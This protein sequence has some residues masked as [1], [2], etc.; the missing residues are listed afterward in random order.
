MLVLVWLP[1][2]MAQQLHILIKVGLIRERKGGEARE[3]KDR[4]TKEGVVELVEEQ[5]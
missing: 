2:N 5:G 4:R 1:T 3:V